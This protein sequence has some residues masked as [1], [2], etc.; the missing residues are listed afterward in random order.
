MSSFAEESVGFVRGMCHADVMEKDKIDLSVL[1]VEDDPNTLMMFGRIAESQGAHCVLVGTFHEAMAALADHRFDMM[2]VDRKLP[3]GDG[4]ELIEQARKIDPRAL[5]VMVT[6]HGTIDIAVQAM[7]MGA[8][9]FLSKPFCFERLEVLLQRVKEHLVSQR[10][11]ERLRRE[12]MEVRAGEMIGSSPAIRSVKERIAQIAPTPSTVLI[13]GETGV[14]KELA[15]RAIHRMSPRSSGPFVVVDCAAIPETLLESTLFG[16]EKGSFTD[17]YT[18]RK[19]MVELAAGGTLLLDEV[20]ELAPSLQSKLLRLLQERVYRPIGSEKEKS[21]NIRVVSATRWDLTSRIRGGL[22]REDLYYRL[23]VITLTIPPLQKRPGDIPILANWFLYQQNVRAGKALERI[24]ES[25]MQL[26]RGYNWPGNVRELE[27]AVEHAVAVATG[28]VIE[29]ELLPK[30]ILDSAPVKE[31]GDPS[32]PVS[33]RDMSFDPKLVP[34]T[35]TWRQYQER[36][37]EPYLESFVESLLER[38]K[39][40]VSA[41]AKDAGLSRN[42]LYMLMRRANAKATENISSS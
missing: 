27:H 42:G 10:E 38:H 16:H 20:A 29:P 1:I 24:S 13:Q 3:D 12:V 6:A 9:D 5:V 25:A 35:M 8:W 2:L 14:G 4:I 18:S 11:N 23:N 28:T 36:V 39:G 19:G 40:N 17:A 22:F 21:A 34:T 15:A 32:S 41:A 26:L 31:P 37:L 33:G 30:T 7:K